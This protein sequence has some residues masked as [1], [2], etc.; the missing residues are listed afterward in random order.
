MG[1]GNR[2]MDFIYFHMFLTKFSSSSQWYCYRSFW[3]VGK[4]LPLCS[5]KISW[6]L[7]CSQWCLYGDFI[8]GQIMWKYSICFPWKSK[9]TITSIMCWNQ[10]RFVFEVEI[11]LC[12]FMDF[13]SSILCS[14][15]KEK[16][17]RVENLLKLSN[18]MCLLVIK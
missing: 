18:P 3:S 8:N 17:L 7:W 2:L 4:L 16:M 6:Y 10:S 15:H 14:Q 9:F 13:K 5:P 1:S 12:S 11:I